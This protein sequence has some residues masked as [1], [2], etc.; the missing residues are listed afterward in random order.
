MCA[1]CTAG[2][3]NVAP[4]V[5]MFLPVAHSLWWERVGSSCSGGW[6]GGCG[7]AGAEVSG[8]GSEQVGF[9]EG[10]LFYRDES[11]GKVTAILIVYVDD[12][13]IPPL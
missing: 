5:R 6:E 10:G 4:S 2:A 3:V 1:A 12:I 9:R 8:N 13:G 11:R 7:A